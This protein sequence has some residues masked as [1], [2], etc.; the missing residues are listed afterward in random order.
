MLR[1]AR[2]MGRIG[3]DAWALGWL[4]C[5]MASAMAGVTST[6]PKMIGAGCSAKMSSMVTRAGPYGPAA[7][8]SAVA[9]AASRSVRRELASRSAAMRCCRCASSRSARSASAADSPW[10][11]R[12]RRVGLWPL[13]SDGVRW[14]TTAVP[15]PQTTRHPSTTFLTSQPTRRHRPAISCPSLCL[16]ATSVVLPWL[17]D[18]PDADAAA[19]GLGLSH[20][21]ALVISAAGPDE[22]QDHVDAAVQHRVAVSAGGRRA[23][24]TRRATRTTMLRWAV[25][26]AFRRVQLVRLDCPAQLPGCGGGVAGCAVTHVTHQGVGGAVDGHHLPQRRYGSAVVGPFRG[27]DRQNPHHCLAFLLGVDL[28]FLRCLGALHATQPLTQPGHYPVLAA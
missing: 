6:R 21:G 22:R 10:S 5:R 7:L 8:A 3:H 23:P 19:A 14:I 18:G 12:I 17:F 16:V 15:S 26:R 9:F 28:G 24:V 1:S 27:S 20:P 25:L 13:R 2:R 11:L 4:R